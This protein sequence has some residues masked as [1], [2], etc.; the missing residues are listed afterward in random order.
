MAPRFGVVGTAHWARHVHLPGL[1]DAGA[2][3]VGIW[4]RNAAVAREIAAEKGV[5]AFASFEDLLASC[6]ALTMAV[7]P[8]VQA[9]LALQAAR[10]GRHMIVEKP[11]S[12]DLTSARLIEKEVTENRLVALVFF[13]RR[14]IPEIAAMIERESGHAW[15]KALVRVHSGAMAG[16]GPY[17]NSQWRR[18]PG[19]ALWDIAPHVL[20]V[21]IP[22]LGEVEAVEAEAET[23]GVTR[24]KTW[25]RRGGTADISVSLQSK[26]EDIANSYRFVSPTRSISLPEPE[27]SRSRVFGHAVGALSEAI[28]SGRRDLPCGVALGREVVDWLQK[29]ELSQKHDQKVV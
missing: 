22:M 29:A 26:P 2:D 28:R 23:G 24:L 17:A 14:F 15:T 3:V 18:E 10:A 1:L 27:F 4:G 9:G 16:A 11:L 21:L 19:A 5:R 12:R 13:M 6:D 20:S 7:P 25:H 8:D